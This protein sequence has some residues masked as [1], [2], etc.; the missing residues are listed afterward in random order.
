MLAFLVNQCLSFDDA[1]SITRLFRKGYY[2]DED[3]LEG[4]VPVEISDRVNASSA[5][6]LK[7]TFVIMDT[8]FS[9]SYDVIQPNQECPKMKGFYELA[10][11]YSGDCQKLGSS[12]RSPKC[13]ADGVPSETKTPLDMKQCVW[14]L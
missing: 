3:T 6:C 13:F 8:M 7:P 10:P 5:L 9:S 1:D 2:P 14:T 12:L 4:R 11:M